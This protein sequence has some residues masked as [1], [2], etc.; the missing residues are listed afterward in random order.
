MMNLIILTQSD[1]QPDSPS[2]QSVKKLNWECKKK[3]SIFI[4]FCSFR[5]FEHICCESARM[6][7]SLS[8]FP[9]N[10]YPINCW[11][12]LWLTLFAV[13]IVKWNQTERAHD[14]IQIN[15]VWHLLKKCSCCSCLFIFLFLS[16]SPKT[17]P[18]P[19]LLLSLFYSTDNFLRKTKWKIRWFKWNW[20][21]SYDSSYLF[22]IPTALNKMHETSHQPFALVF[23]SLTNIVNGR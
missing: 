5:L 10:W 8:K 9:S 23:Y 18:P 12:E 6:I 19:P 22:H 1:S 3:Y 13:G 16:L 15:C 20:P 14:R 2:W 21:R 17:P 7:V 4:S 11:F